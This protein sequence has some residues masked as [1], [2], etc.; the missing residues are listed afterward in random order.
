MGA[1]LVA[2]VIVLDL[3]LPIGL[4]VWA[5]MTRAKSGIY[6]GSIL[7]LTAIVI[8]VLSPFIFGFWHV[9]GSFWPVFY[10]VAFVAIL[11]FKVLRGLPAQWLPNGWS[12]ETF[13]TGLNVVHAALWALLIPPLLQAR[14]YEGQALSLSS[15]LRGGDF[16]VVSGGGN[17]A[18]NQHTDYAMDIAKLNAFGFSAAGFYPEDLQKHA[19]FGT[20]IIAPCAGEVIA[21]ENS[22]PN[23]RPLD[24]DSD[25][26][27][28]GNHIVIFCEGHSVHLAH[29]QPGSVAVSVGDQVAVG[30]MLGRVGNSGNT[31]QPHL[32]INAVRGRHIFERA[33]DGSP[34]GAASAPFLIDGKFLIK[35]DSFSN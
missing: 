8:G 17:G 24:P 7:V 34:W 15:P 13:L 14:S 4:L 20:E 3:I 35:G 23:R 18:V 11:A 29:L 32:H 22:K 26:L 9:V 33:E 5:F 1:V 27:R 25:D 16:Y 31:M 10:L 21:A 28:G 30:Q 19:V 12:W 6:L 2:I